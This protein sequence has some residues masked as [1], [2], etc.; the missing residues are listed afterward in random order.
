MFVDSDSLASIATLYSV[1]NN[2]EG[3]QTTFEL[4]KD[5]AVV[6]HQTSTIHA[7]V[8]ARQTSVID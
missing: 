7:F 8:S 4:Q 6:G 3:R 1:Q 2:G 5:L